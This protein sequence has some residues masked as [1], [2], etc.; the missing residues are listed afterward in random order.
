MGALGEQEHPG[1]MPRLSPFT[2][3]GLEMEELTVSY[4]SPKSA[5]LASSD[6]RRLM[7]TTSQPAEPED[8]RL[9]QGHDIEIEPEG[10]RFCQYPVTSVGFPKPALSAATEDPQVIDLDAALVTSH[11]DTETS[12]DHP[13]CGSPCFGDACH[14]GFNH[15]RRQYV[16]RDHLARAQ[17]CGAVAGHGKADP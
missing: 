16:L 6:G 4:P 9:S 7:E 12:D 3:A 5:A 2:R 13:T 14:C 11:W 1:P 8:D 10:G 15:C 17:D